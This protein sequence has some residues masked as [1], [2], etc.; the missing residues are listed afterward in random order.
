MQ[1]RRV[2]FQ[3]LGLQ[4][5][6][7]VTFAMALWAMHHL[8]PGDA[9]NVLV[10]TP[11]LPGI[12]IIAWT[13]WVYRVCDEFIRARILAAAA[14]TAMVVAAG[15]LVYSY[16]ELTGLPRLSMAWVS[17]V[18]WVVFDAQMLRLLFQR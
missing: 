17:N 2:I 11:V 18:G 5:A 14:A 10:M 16:L 7:W 9:R 3:F 4:W 6:Y 12:L 13:S 8:G 15:S 1:R